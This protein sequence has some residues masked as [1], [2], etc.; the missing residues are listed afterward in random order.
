ML[1]MTDGLVEDRGVFLD[2]NL[3]KLRMAAAEASAAEIE[4]FANHLMS[5]F[6]PREDDVAMIALRRVPE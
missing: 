3:E 2:D 6:G 5:V 1:L 4:A